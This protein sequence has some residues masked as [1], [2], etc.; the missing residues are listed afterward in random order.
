MR[1]AGLKYAG[2]TEAALVAPLETISSI[3][4]AVLLLNEELMPI[5]WVGSFLVVFSVALVSVQPGINKLAPFMRR[6]NILINP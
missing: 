5:Q 1:F 4:L 6:M 3:L 2:N